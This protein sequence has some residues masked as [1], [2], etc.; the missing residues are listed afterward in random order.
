MMT[1]R[2]LAKVRWVKAAAVVAGVSNLFRNAE[3]RPAM[4]ENIFKPYFGGTKKAMRERSAAFWPD[5]FSKK[6]PLLIMHGTGDWR[7]SPLDSI[8]LAE[9]LYKNKVPYRLVL[10]EGA[11]HRLSEAH[12]ESGEQA[13]RWFE[14]FL[15]KK[16]PLPNLKKHG[17]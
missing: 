12:E 10:F 8:E 2:A 3:D 9:G 17:A 16:E 1:Y 7:V 15:K 11:D 14:R 13:L 5:K 6:S 4:Y